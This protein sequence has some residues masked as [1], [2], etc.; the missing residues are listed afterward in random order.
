MIITKTPLRL[1]LGGGGTDLPFFFPKYGG[2]LVTAAIDKYI[3]VTV[4]RRKFHNQFRVSY[5]KTENVGRVS[6]I[7]NTRVKAAL[8]LLGITEPLE[9]TTIAEVPGSSGLGSSSAFLVGLLNA[10]HAFKGESVS[11]KILAE[12]AAKI[13]IDI[14][15]EPIGKQDQY[16]SALGGINHLKINKEGTILATPLNIRLETIHD[17][18]RNLHMF[19][20]GITRD[21]STVLKDQAKNSNSKIDKMQKMIEIKEIGLKIKDSL[22]KSDLKKFGRLMNLHWETK[23][24]T[25]EKVSDSRIDKWYELAIKKGALGGK[26][27]GAGG[28]GFF[29]FY[30]DKDHSN[31]IKTMSNSGLKYVPFRFEMDGSKILLNAK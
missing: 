19:F 5:S 21:A 6:E 4:S 20:T 16:A 25:S 10:L 30:C 12:E 26:I 23:K 27:M 22:E 8:N 18:E 7:E 28:G 14:L 15:G 2:E 1:P 9:I 29:I 13:E 31:F 3:Y 11:S 24:K 17:L